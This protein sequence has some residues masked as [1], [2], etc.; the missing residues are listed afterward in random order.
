MFSDFENNLVILAEKIS[1]E[2]FSFIMP[3]LEEVFPPLPSPSVTI[4]TGFLAY[5]REYSLLALL[6]LIILTVIG[7]TMGA[8]VLYFLM[9]KVEDILST[10]FGKYIGISHKQIEYFGSHLGQGPRDYFILTL[11]RALPFFPS[12][13]VSVGSGLLKVKLRLFLISTFI[14]SLIRNSFYVYLGYLGTSAGLSFIKQTESLTSIIKISIVIL[15]FIFLIW[16]YF[17]RRKVL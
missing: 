16:V 8:W 9:D 14:G 15:V 1:L 6:F 5:L 17:H 2:F 7:K 13:L 3:F 12:T 10:K 11:I 4:I